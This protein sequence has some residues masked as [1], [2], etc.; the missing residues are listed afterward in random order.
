M[1]YDRNLGFI[2]IEELVDLLGA[3]ENSKESFPTFRS[4]FP[5]TIGY[6]EDLS[7]RI[8]REGK[9]F[10]QRSPHVIGIFPFSNSSENVNPEISNIVLTFD[11]PLDDEK[12]NSIEPNKSGDESS[13]MVKQLF[14]NDNGTVM[15]LIV[16]LKPDT[17]YEY[18]LPGSTFITADGYPL[19]NYVLKF[20][21]EK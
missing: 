4:L 2:W 17:E 15:T 1:I 6:F 8:E 13:Q 16:E 3:Y 9:E 12:V 7:K 10:E 5:L 11:K 18:E 21:T 20:K 14:L 19:Q